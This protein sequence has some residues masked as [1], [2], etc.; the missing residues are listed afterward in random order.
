MK[1]LLAVFCFLATLSAWADEPIYRITLRSTP[2]F[3]LPTG[4]YNLSLFPLSERASKA[5]NQNKTRKLLAADSK[6][7]ILIKT[8]RPIVALQGIQRQ[9]AE[10]SGLVLGKVMNS[11]LDEIAPV[12]LLPGF[13]DTSV[14]N[15]LLTPKDTDTY[16]LTISYIIY[17]RPE[18]SID[19]TPAAI[20]QM[21]AQAKEMKAMAE[22]MKAA[23]KP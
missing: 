13:S 22:Q 21:N 10:Q 17:E 3:T 12:T 15:L 8:S 16:I 14:I 11:S 1:L 23:K 19:G 5:L 9:L 6:T 18:G 7:G 20:E 4:D 2:S